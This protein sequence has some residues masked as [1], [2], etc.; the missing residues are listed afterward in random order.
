M[1]ISFRIDHEINLNP[2]Y[3]TDVLCWS[4]DRIHTLSDLVDEKLQF[5]W[6]FPKNLNY[7]SLKLDNGL[8]GKLNLNISSLF[9]FNNEIYKF[10]TILVI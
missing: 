1:I 7:T 4:Q 8:S 5:V 10:Q 3:I 2:E 6:I 9:S